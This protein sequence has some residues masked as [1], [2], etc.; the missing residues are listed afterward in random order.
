MP[1]PHEHAAR[2][3]DP[4][5]YDH[6]ARENDKGGKGIDFIFGRKGNGPMEL[7]A[8]RFDAD[9]FTVEQAKEWLKKHNIKYILFYLKRT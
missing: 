4:K 8:I 6:F 2:I 3:K 7:Q 1:Y 9:A 5:N